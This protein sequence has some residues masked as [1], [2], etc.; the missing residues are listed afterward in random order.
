MSYDDNVNK[1]IILLGDEKFYWVS[2][3]IRF[4]SI[5][6]PKSTW[7]KPN[8]GDWWYT[9]V[10]FVVHIFWD[11]VVNLISWPVHA[12]CGMSPP[13]VDQKGPKQWN[14]NSCIEVWCVDIHDSVSFKRRGWSFPKLS[15]LWKWSCFWNQT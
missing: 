13:S 14:D 10:Q 11:F 9:G 12:V 4:D 1:N 2:S 8:F 5:F 15:G 7:S 3:K 6:I